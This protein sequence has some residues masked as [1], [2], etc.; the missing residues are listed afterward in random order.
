[1]RRK[2]TTAEAALSPAAITGS[3]TLDNTLAITREHIPAVRAIE[4][5]SNACLCYRCAA[6]VP[7]PHVALPKPADLSH[8]RLKIDDASVEVIEGAFGRRIILKS[9]NG[10]RQVQPFRMRLRAKMGI[11]FSAWLTVTALS[12]FA[13]PGMWLL[14]WVIVGLVCSAFLWNRWATA[15]RPSADCSAIDTAWRELVP[16][17]QHS[18]PLIAL[19][20]ASI[21]CGSTQHRS[22]T[23]RRLIE[24][25]LEECEI[26]TGDSQ[27]LATARILRAFDSNKEK[28]CGIA[29][30]FEPFFAGE[31][32]AAYAEAAAQTVIE[33]SA[34]PPGDLKRLRILL[35]A[36]AF[37]SGFGPLD[38]P[39]LL[40]P[41]RFLRA[42]MAPA[43]VKPLCEL[44][45]LWQGVPKDAGAN[46]GTA[47]GVFELAANAPALTKKV[48]ARWPDALLR[49]QLPESLQKGIGEV[50]LT[51][52]GLF[53]DNLL[54]EANDPSIEIERSP[55]G[56][57]WY[58]AVGHQKV[59]VDRKPPMKIANV[60]AAWLEYCS[61]NLLAA[62]Q[63]DTLCNP[64]KLQQF[65]VQSLVECPQ[66]GAAN[67][68][69]AGGVGE[70][71]P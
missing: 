13:W 36:A 58:I 49:I 66:C 27:L 16:K 34:M 33:S 57:G 38:I 1:M 64:E 31:L 40:K 21:G 24:R 68:V 48:L 69:I 59:S 67:V 5:D 23:L 56:S 30:V 44:Y 50:V 26:G 25:T 52:R 63:R 10:R 12:F 2:D 46:T 28:T 19:C 8:G 4:A 65:T 18:K 11:A 61:V 41:L 71:L 43:E 35:L 55:T 70:R 20:R 39:R 45:S 9:P 32:P 47:T 6:R 62:S 42:L 17:I 22:K 7:S 3:E 15:L 53:L 60:L 37:E 54:I 51:S 29:G 14:G